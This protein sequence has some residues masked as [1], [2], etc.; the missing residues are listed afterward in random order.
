[1]PT[2]RCSVRPTKTMPAPSSGL[3]DLGFLDRILL[4]QDVF[5]KMMLTHYG[6][7]GYAY[8]VT[9]LRR[10]AEAAWRHRRQIT[11]MLIDNPRRVF[12]RRT[13]RIRRPN[14]Q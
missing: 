5:I 13:E 10:A 14:D 3:I 11:T 1:M 8:V 9:P 4:S 6:G 2:S 7:F 12:Q